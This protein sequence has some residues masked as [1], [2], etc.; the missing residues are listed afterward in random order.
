MNLDRELEE[1]LTTEEMDLLLETS[2]TP[3]RR[4]AEHLERCEACRGEAAALRR[5]DRELARLPRFEV[6]PQFVASVMSRVRL[7]V[8]LYQRAWAAVRER[9][10]LVAATLVAVA[11]AA[12]ALGWWMLGSRGVTPVALAAYA[13]E[14]LRA[15][16]LQGI[17][18]VG[19][20]AYEIGAVDLVSGLLQGVDPVQGLAMLAAV[21]SLGLAAL[22]TAWKLMERPRLEGSRA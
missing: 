22:L 9:L 21:G 15:A 16:V 13:V 2:E 10:L 1:H 7:P 4:V 17:I 20:L 18:A 8:P 19:R 12:T 11:A 6:G 14:A 5:L 3:P